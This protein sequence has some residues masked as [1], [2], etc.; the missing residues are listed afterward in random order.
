VTP[1]HEQRV[2]RLVVVGGLPAVVAAVWFVFDSGIGARLQWALAVVVTGS[3][4]GTAIAVRERVVRPLQTLSNMVAALR[5]QDYSLRARGARPEDALGLALWEVNTLSVEMHDRR[6]GALEAGALLRR[7]MAEIDVA[8]YA[9]DE[10]NALRVVNAF[11]ARLL[12]QPEERLLGRSADDLGLGACLTGSAPRIMDVPV[13]ASGGRWE[14]RRGA[15]RQD[16]RPHRFIVLADVSRTLREEERLAW[17]RLIRVLAH[18]INNSITPIQSLA[19]RLQELVRREARG[20][21]LRTPMPGTVRAAGMAGAPSDATV[22]PAAGSGP[23]L[24]SAELRDDLERGLGVITSRAEALTRFIATYTQL[25]RL[26]VPKKRPVRVADWVHRVAR[27]ESRVRVQVVPGPDATIDADGDQLD[28]LLINLVKNAADA[29]QG[30]DGGVRVRWSI[31]DTTL[32]VVVEDD[33]P[34]V[35]DTANLFVPFYTTKD[36]GTGVGLVLS[37]QIAEAHGGSVTLANRTGASGCEARLLL[38]LS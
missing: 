25:A 37:R 2:F 31:H 19:G 26:P 20:E 7:V 10:G 3:W 29:V 6:L 38:P 14:L 18:E 34:G 12:G 22:T 36:G 13:G 27:L 1:T 24:A 35:G 15:F 16:G 17:Q 4:L 33:G 8:V 32:A 9:F 5:E 11:G 30:G 28:Q 21:P 23:G